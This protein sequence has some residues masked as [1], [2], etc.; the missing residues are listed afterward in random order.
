MQGLFDDLIGNVRTVEVAG[1]DV[2]DPECDSFPE[3]RNCGLNIARRSKYVW[4]SQLHRAIAGTV[5][6]H[7]GARE[8]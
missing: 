3:H 2:I 7:L 6:G 8:A 1:V 4:A 5:Q